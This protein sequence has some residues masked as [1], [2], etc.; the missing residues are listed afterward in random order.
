M[1]NFVLKNGAVLRTVPPI[2]FV[3]TMAKTRTLI[4]ETDMSYDNL[5][6][7]LSDYNN[8]SKIECKFDSGHILEV[9]TDCAK[10]KEL[11]RKDDGTYS[12]IFST[13]LTEKALQE[14]QAKV[15]VLKRQNEEMQ[16][17]IN[18]LLAVIPDNP[19]DEQQEE[20]LEE[21]QEEA[22]EETGETDPDDTGTED[23]TGEENLEP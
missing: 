23:E 3:N 18:S 11:S 12:A 2:A 17:R 6:N 4:F 20:E 1:Q 9:Y 10:L 14:L 15:E 5:F 19:A 16:E 21:I 7:M 22:P 8:I 13:D